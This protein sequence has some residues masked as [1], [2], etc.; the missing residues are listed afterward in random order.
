LR[1]IC[2]IRKEIFAALVLDIPKIALF[3]QEKM[4][5]FLPKVHLKLFEDLRDDYLYLK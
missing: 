4:K 2:L 1:R 3:L 5:K